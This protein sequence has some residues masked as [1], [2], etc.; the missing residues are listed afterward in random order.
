MDVNTMGHAD[1]FVDSEFNSFFIER[2]EN[3]VLIYSLELYNKP[4][5]SFISESDLKNL[6]S[7]ADMNYEFNKDLIEKDRYLFTYDLCSYFGGMNFDS[8]PFEL[9]YEEFENW[10]LENFSEN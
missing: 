8:M 10:F 2:F 9:S 7:F 4:S 1:F 3:K 5:D 6:N